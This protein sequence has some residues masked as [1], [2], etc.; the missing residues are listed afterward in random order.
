MS[1]FVSHVA[2]A[3]ILFYII[4][5]VG[6]H[7]SNFGYLQLSLFSNTDQSPAFNFILKAF[8]PTVY[9]ILVSTFFYAFHLD[10]LVAHIWAVA[11]Y[12]FSFRVLFNIAFGRVVLLDWPVQLMQIITGIGAAFLAYRHLV[13][14]RHPLFPDA[15]EI[16]TQLWVIVALFLYATLNNVRVSNRRGVQRKKRYISTRFMALRKQYAGLV[17]GKLSEGYMEL[18][19]YAILIHETFNRPWLARVVERAVFPWGSKTLGPMQVQTITR[20]SDL[21]SVRIGVRRL[22]EDFDMTNRE[23]T[24]KAVSRYDV[25][26]AAL[27]K[28]NRDENYIQEVFQLIHILWAQVA[29]EYRSEFET[30]YVKGSGQV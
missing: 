10:H 20:I 23:L 15:H 8:A 2:L 9:I 17:Q 4:N 16:G 5:W 6:E 26:R 18:V 12:Y 24:G 30:M 1:I 11:A 13:L 7:S 14:P 29:P 19:A 27:A 21:E 3:I 28:Y 25:I 22:Q